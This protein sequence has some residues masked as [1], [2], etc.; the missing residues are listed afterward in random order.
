MQGAPQENA[1]ATAKSQDP[2]HWQVAQA[3]RVRAE[4]HGG[5]A[6][7][8]EKGTRKK[9]KECGKGKEKLTLGGPYE[10]DS[11]PGRQLDQKNRDVVLHPLDPSCGRVRKHCMWTHPLRHFLE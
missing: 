2:H 1:A 7:G 6:S 10:A 8:A 4:G 5:L 11:I 9:R 3:S